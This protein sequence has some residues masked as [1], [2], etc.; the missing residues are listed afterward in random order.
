MCTLQVGTC[1]VAGTRMD[2]MCTVQFGTCFV[3]GTSTE[4]ICTVQLVPFLW[5]VQVE[6]DMYCTVWYLFYGWYKH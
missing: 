3:A 1:S 4:M 5:L 6:D 2:M